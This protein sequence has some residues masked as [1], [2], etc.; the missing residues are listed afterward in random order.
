VQRKVPGYFDFLI[1]AFRTGETG[2]HVHFGYWD[3]PPPLAAPCT[4]DEFEA[5][6]ARLCDLIIDL[7]GFANGQHVLDVGCGFGGTLAALNARWNRMTLVG[8]NLDDR[9]LAICQTIARRASNTLACVAADACELPFG[10]DCFDRIVCL[11]AIFHFR[12]RAEFFA[13]AARSLRPG[14]LL[15][16][17]DFLIRPPGAAAPFPTPFVERVI[18]RDYGPWP[19]IWMAADAIRAVAARAGLA[20][21]QEIDLTPQTLPTHRVTAPIR[22]TP[23]APAAGDLLR[24]LHEHGFLSYVGLVLARK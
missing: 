3:D 11:E 20:L 9:Q 2:R 16:M 8:L 23:S 15:V 12:S 6:Q 10:P 13:Q 14:G 7:A 22:S 24:W 4:A 21:E 18:R 17:T 1:P 5:A 19:D